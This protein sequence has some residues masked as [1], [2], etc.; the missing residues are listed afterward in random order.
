M[1]SIKERFKNFK[2]R[3]V[4]EQAI[5]D[6]QRKIISSYAN[7]LKEL[8][9]RLDRGESPDLLLQDLDKIRNEATDKLLQERIF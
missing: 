1:I 3:E 2:A 6:N 4:I 5:Q 7:Q 8:L 9:N